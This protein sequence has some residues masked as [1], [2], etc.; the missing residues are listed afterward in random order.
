M[1]VIISIYNNQN[2][3]SK[4]QQLLDNLDHFQRENADGT[5]FFG[6]NTAHETKTGYLRSVKPEEGFDKLLE[7]Y[8][9]AHF[10]F[11]H[12]TQGK[13]NKDNVH[14]WKY[15]QWIMAHNGQ[16]FGGAEYQD[17]LSDSNLLFRELAKVG[18]FEK[19]KLDINKINKIVSQRY[20]WGRLIF[21][22]TESKQ[23]YYFGDFYL[24][25]LDYNILIVST[26]TLKKDDLILYGMMFQVQS[27]DI[28][29]AKM[30][31]I[32]KIDA[33]QEKLK[34]Y[35]LNFNE[36]KYSD[37]WPEWELNDTPVYNNNYQR[38]LNWRK[39]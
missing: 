39:I 12:A 14:F 15:K 32:F 34:K 36:K 28:I 30:E 16:I 8:N 24:S 4:N 6:W 25:V 3:R 18:V 35:K 29:E 33:K 20:F 10:H 23:T 13:I 26:Q 27:R 37:P 19:E 1:C 31:G 22:N 38:S 9:I 2:N 11:R 17:E 5:A 7:R 21:V